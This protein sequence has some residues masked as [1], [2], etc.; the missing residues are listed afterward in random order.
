MITRKLASL[1]QNNT[2]SK[3]RK[4]KTARKGSQEHQSS[5]SKTF[6]FCPLHLKVVIQNI[7]CKKAVGTAKVHLVPKALRKSYSFKGISRIAGFR[8]V[9]LK[10]DCA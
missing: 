7:H 6:T 3:H 5:P 4:L 8:L 2:N 9:T 10:Y 1:G